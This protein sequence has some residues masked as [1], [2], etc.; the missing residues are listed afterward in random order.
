[1]KTAKIRPEILLLAAVSTMFVVV[2]ATEP[3][4]GSGTGSD[5]K[6]TD[7]ENGTQ[8]HDPGGEVEEPMSKGKP[9]CSQP[10]T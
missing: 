6:V 4:S 10:K 9:S 1:M 5:L 3:G 2:A 8:P 7:G